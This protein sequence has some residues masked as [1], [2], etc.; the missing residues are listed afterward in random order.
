M[1]VIQDTWDEPE[2][3]ELIENAKPCVTLPGE[4][5][6][7][8]NPLDY[9]CVFA[10]TQIMQKLLRVDNMD[11]YPLH[12][13]G[14]YKRNILLCPVKEFMEKDA[15]M[16]VKPWKNNK[17][18]DALVLNPQDKYDRDYLVSKTESLEDLVYVCELVTFL[19][20]F[21]LFVAN[22]RLHGMQES[23]A[24][25]LPEKQI[26]SRRPS[27]EFI[28]TVLEKN[29]DKFCVI[30]VGEIQGKGFCVVEVNPPFALSSY[31]YPIEKYIS[32][33]SSAYRHFAT[34]MEYNK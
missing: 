22:G 18:F 14:L 9:K 4:K 17:T 12:F 24:Y 5:V 23:S 25:V 11:T 13:H 33:C 8:L 2:D 6:L 3:Q 30:D 32:F 27:E 21:R 34:R 29:R 10:D 1:F 16:F 31:D 19:N 20:E 26:A 15:P 7:T 28:K